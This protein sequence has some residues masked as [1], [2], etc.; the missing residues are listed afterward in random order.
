MITVGTSVVT[1]VGTRVVA[2]GAAAHLVVV[3][4]LLLLF[5]YPLLSPGGAGTLVAGAA[6]IALLGGVPA[7]LCARW[8]VRTPTAVA[9]AALGAAVVAELAVAGPLIARLGGERLTTGVP[10]LERYVASWPTLLA[11]VLLAGLVEHHLRRAARA[12]WPAALAVA[13]ATAVAVPGLVLVSGLGRGWWEAPP[14]ALVWGTPPLA[15]LAFAAALLLSRARLVAPATVLAAALLAATG[16]SWVQ[17]AGD[18]VAG[19]LTVALLYLVVAL[20][21]GVVESGVRALVR[22]TRLIG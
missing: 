14:P 20:L 9:V 11:V 3:G 7:G 6:G 16:A 17:R 21:L 18:P 1:R 4:V 10:V 8:A 5:G 19:L 2:A 22:R 12:P 15:L 13:A